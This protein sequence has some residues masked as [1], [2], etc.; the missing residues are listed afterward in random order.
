MDGQGE[1]QKD[2]DCPEELKCFKAGKFISPPTG[3]TFEGA[4]GTLASLNRKFRFC[5]DPSPKGKIIFFG[6]KKQQQKIVTIIFSINYSNQQFRQ[7][8]HFLQKKISMK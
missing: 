4:N 7:N 8:Y 3:Y 5:Y 6:I 1:C 2:S